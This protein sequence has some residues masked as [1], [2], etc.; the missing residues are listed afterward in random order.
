VR[1]GKSD[2][3]KGFFLKAQFIVLQGGSAMMVHI[4][5]NA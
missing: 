3:G 2:I 4:E 5:K 1:E